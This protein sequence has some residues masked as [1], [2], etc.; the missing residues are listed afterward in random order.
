[1]KRQRLVLAVLV[2]AALA[3]LAW[4][5]LAPGPG[6]A[7]TLSGYIEGEA[8]YLSSPVAGT[9]ETLAV[10]RGQHVPAGTRLFSI[11][12]R[13]QA[14]ESAAAAAEVAAHR[15]AVLR[16]GGGVPVIRECGIGLVS[17]PTTVVEI[18][19]ARRLPAL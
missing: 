16:A 7:R 10:R 18:P 9:V 15:V 17:P 1:M 11:E 14:A 19:R 2:V 8:L 12:P 4:L 6:R 5:W 13:R 3:L